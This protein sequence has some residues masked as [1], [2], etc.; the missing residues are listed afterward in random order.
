MSFVSSVSFFFF[1]LLSFYRFPFLVEIIFSSKGNRWERRSG[2]GHE[3][4]GYGGKL[5][6]SLSSS[7]QYI[8]ITGHFV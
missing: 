6:P 3:T 8:C 1:D 2:G 5:R 4:M 7:T